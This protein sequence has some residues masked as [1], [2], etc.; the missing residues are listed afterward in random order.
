MF[1]KFTHFLGNQLTLAWSSSYREE[2]KRV[3]LPAFT[4]GIEKLVKD[5]E[6]LLMNGLSRR[7]C[8]PFILFQIE[9]SLSLPI[10]SGF[11]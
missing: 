8:S 1:Q 3:V 4:A 7:K 5:V 2:M 11:P 6:I 10:Y 9:K